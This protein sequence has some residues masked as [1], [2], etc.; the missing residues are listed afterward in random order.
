MPCSGGPVTF[1]LRAAQGNAPRYCVG[2]N[3]RDTWLELMT[4]RGDVVLYSPECRLHCSDCLS[5]GCDLI[6]R[7]PQPLKAEG[8]RFT[9]H[10]SVWVP[11]TCG[12]GKG[13][14]AKTC[15][16]PGQ[17]VAKM[18]ATSN[19]LDSTV[20][21]QPPSV[22]QNCVE[23]KFVYPSILTVVEGILP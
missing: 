13:C 15:A 1:Q 4:E 23:V 6:C 10:G 11:S 22:P 3:C 17:Y 20:C 5:G 19:A 2:R 7:N 18:C 9:W 14:A 8:E 16:T 21:R 12:T